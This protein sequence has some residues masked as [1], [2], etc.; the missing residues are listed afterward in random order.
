MKR[1]DPITIVRYDPSRPA[2]FERERARVA[3]AL[4]PWL[5]GPVEHI[6][7]TAVAG[8][9]AKPVIDMLARVEDYEQGRAAVAG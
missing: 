1:L 2:L 5:S 9:A 3:R 8:L 6:G 7:S 4:V